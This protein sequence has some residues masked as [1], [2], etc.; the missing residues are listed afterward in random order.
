MQSVDGVEVLDV[1]EA[2][3]YIG[4]TPETVRRVWS[5]RV[6]ASRQ[7]NRL[8]IARRALDAAVSG[9]P[10][11]RALSLR[12]WAANTPR[13]TDRTETSATSLVPQ[14]RCS[15]DHGLRGNDT[16]LD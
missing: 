16:I 1:W 11:S 10:P 6:A 7:G 3:A 12:E 13:R 15:D 14:D 2:A 5:G 4:R 8:L 9:V